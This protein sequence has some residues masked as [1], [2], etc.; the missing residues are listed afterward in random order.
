MPH[1]PGHMNRKST[2]F[3]L[4]YRD[5]YGYPKKPTYKTNPSP[6]T[7]PKRRGYEKNSA[8]NFDREFAKEVRAVNTHN[9]G[10]F[11][12]DPEGLRVGKHGSRT[13]GYRH[14]SNIF[15][16]RGMRAARGPQRKGQAYTS[17][18]YQGAKRKG[19]RRK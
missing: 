5:I 11:V 14:V 18:S 7:G 19:G 12:K 9:M 1:K 10:K 8:R 6:R 16:T 13:G 3:P 2:R 17:P 15:R 4:I